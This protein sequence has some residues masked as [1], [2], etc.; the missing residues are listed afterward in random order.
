VSPFVCPDEC[1][2]PILASTCLIYDGP[3]IPAFGITTNQSLTQVV[4]N[5]AFGLGGEGGPSPIYQGDS[6][7]TV[8]V[9]D[10]PTGTNI[11]G[12]SYDQLFE[13][14]YA[15]FVHP[16]FES[17]GI[18]NQVQNV[19]VGTLVSGTK[20][21][22]ATYNNIWNVV[23]NSLNIFKGTPTNEILIGSS[24]PLLN[25]N[26]DIG[27]NQFST[28][29]EIYFKGVCQ[30]TNGQIFNSDIFIISWMYKIY[31][32][33]STSETLTAEQIV[34]LNIYNGLSSDFKGTY[35]FPELSNDYPGEYKFFCWP[36]SYGSPLGFDD[37]VTMFNIGM[38]GNQLEPSFQYQQNGLYYSIVNI[39]IENVGAVPYR[40]YRT[41]NKL[42][43]N[44]KITIK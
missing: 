19:E 37:Q 3:D 20:P 39:P 24:L 11:Y 18:T 29:N 15:P 21:F 22:F 43:G 17:F 35:E 10:I 2:T 44:I 40:V 38:A 41:Y 31:I 8:T 5:L 13:N 36:D 7:S 6:P 1:C 4:Q 30:K 23:N 32:G 16:T 12:Y 14:I 34:Q 26:L 25:V 27:Q 28:P 42:S 33:Q 9:N